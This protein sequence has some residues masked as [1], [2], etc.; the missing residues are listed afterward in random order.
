MNFVT[1]YLYSLRYHRA[2]DEKREKMKEKALRQ[3]VAYV[4]RNSPAIGK[5]YENVPED[6]S[7]SDL[8]ITNKQ[9]IMS[10]YE[11]WLTDRTVT[12]EELDAYL[13]DN[14]NIGRFFRGKR[15][16]AKTSGSTGYPLVMIH[17]MDFTNNNITD[18]FFNNALSHLPTCLVL[19]TSIFTQP[20]VSLDNS[21]KR[22]GIMRG[23]LFHVDSL[24][25]A[26]KMVAALNKIRP[27]SLMGTPS[28]MEVLAEECEKGNLKI[29]CREVIC[30]SEALSES[31]R[32]YMEKVFG[33]PVK[34]IY[35]CTETGNIAFECSH[36]RHHIDCSRTIIELVDDDNNPV[37]KGTRSA[38]ILVTNLS[39]RTL[40]IIR[41]EV[42]DSLVWHD[43]G[44]CPCGSREPWV[45]FVG[46][47]SAPLLC[48]EKDGKTTKLSPIMLYALLETLSTVRRFQLVLHGSDRLECRI[49]YMPDIDRATAFAEITCLL[50]DYLAENGVDGVE[51]YESEL[52]PQVDPKTHKVKTVYQV[53]E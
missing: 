15:L 30:N 40:P 33:C 44:D 46:R 16:I 3:L 36:Y 11:N 51:I 53:E 19:P 28:T 13:S 49:T 34:S 39:D 50:T 42:A 8:P 1:S 43:G 26:D 24:Q 31:C 23:K 48:F 45:E 38:K 47:L 5:L 37:P 6:F 12:R 27:Q 52:P 18:S 10:D 21:I 32:A 2:S 7:L 9:M 20:A 25:S 17:D 29:K 4:R 41:Y 22:F 35:G 14:D